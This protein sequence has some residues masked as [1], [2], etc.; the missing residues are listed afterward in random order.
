MPKKKSAKAHKYFRTYA[1][2]SFALKIPM[3]EAVYALI[4][5][6]RHV[7]FYAEFQ[8]IFSS[9]IDQRQALDTLSR[10]ILIFDYAIFEVTKEYQELMKKEKGKK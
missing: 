2:E 7:W 8:A 1:Q 9:G 3:D 5:L 10:T 4:L 6:R